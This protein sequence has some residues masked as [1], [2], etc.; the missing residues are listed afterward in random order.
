M[1]IFRTISLD[2]AKVQWESYLDDIT[3][4]QEGE[5]VFYKRDDLWAPLGDGGINGFKVRQGVW[6]LSTLAAWADNVLFAGS[7]RS[8]QHAMVAT[9]ARHFKMQ[10]VHVLGATSEKTYLRHESVAIA[11]AMGARF[12][13]IKVGYNPALQKRV[14]ELRADP[15]FARSFMVEYG[16]GLSHQDWPAQ[17]VYA[18]HDL[19]AAQVVNFPWTMTELVVP[20]GS[21]HAAVSAIAGLYK[22]TRIPTLHLVGLGPSRL[23]WMTE[24]LAVLGFTAQFNQAAEGDTTWGTITAA[25]WKITVAFHDLIGTGYA[26]YQDR[27]VEASDGIEFHPTYEAKMMRWLRDKRPDLLK[28][29]TVVWVVGA[30]PKL[31]YMQQWVAA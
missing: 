19:G 9:V 26:R 10:S 15:A 1:T 3:P 16:V 2:R 21:C 11:H 23:A 31:P 8:T 13:F 27:W 30:E 14:R 24:R 25:D 17:T 18:Y 12:D 28:K 7:V 4:I 6:M 20:A 5:S 22:F 29:S